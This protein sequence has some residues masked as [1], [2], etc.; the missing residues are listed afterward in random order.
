MKNIFFLPTDQPSKLGYHFDVVSSGSIDYAPN[1]GFDEFNTKKNYQHRPFHLYITSDEDINLG[2]WLIWRNN[3]L[4]DSN[5]S[6][7]GVD[8]SECKKILFTTDKKLIADGIQAIDD[9]F[10]KW[11][12]KNPGCEEIEVKKEMYMPFDGKVAF[13]L[14]LDESLNTRPYYKI[15][16]PKEEPIKDLTYWKNNCEEDYLHT[17]ISVLKYISELEKQL[18]I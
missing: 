8:Y 9:E 1:F 3:V 18:N 11:F 10:L 12:V 5:R 16:T 4:R 13:E 15:I 7:T 17:P 14:A 2:D 6:F